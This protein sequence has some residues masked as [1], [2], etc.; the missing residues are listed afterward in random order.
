VLAI[1]LFRGGVI[2]TRAFY[3]AELQVDLPF[4]PDDDY[5]AVCALLDRPP[6]SAGT[7]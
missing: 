7:R 2:A 1:S 3:A 5:A 4:T 6:P